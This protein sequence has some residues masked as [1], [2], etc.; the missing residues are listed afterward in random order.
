MKF[1]KSETIFIKRYLLN[2]FNLIFEFNTGKNP[3]RWSFGLIVPIY[4]K[5]DQSN[6]ENYRDTPYNRLYSYMIEKQI[7][8]TS[9][10]CMAQ[11]IASFSLK[12]FKGVS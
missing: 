5:D 7:K 11:L 12:T 9:E 3:I 4:K 2:L 8:A 1:Q 6:V 10:K